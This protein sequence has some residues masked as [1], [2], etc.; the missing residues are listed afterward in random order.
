M[1]DLFHFMYFMVGKVCYIHVCDLHIAHCGSTLPPS[2]P[3]SLPLSLPLS[4]FLFLSPKLTWRDMQYLLIY[5]ANPTNLKDGD[6]TTNGAGLQVGN[7]FGF[8]A[9]DAEAVVTRARYWKNVPGVLVEE[10][11]VIAE[12]RY[13]KF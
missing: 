7:K 2:L 3:P 5:T 4:L 11:T 9:V 13:C 8:G 1:L 10:Y 12:D 6:F